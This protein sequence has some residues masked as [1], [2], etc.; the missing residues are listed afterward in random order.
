M[1]FKLTKP[2]PV[3]GIAAIAAAG[4]L[5]TYL[6][7]PWV[8]TYNLT[9]AALNGDTRKI[10]QLVD[11][12]RV[13]ETLKIQLNKKLVEEMES[14]PEM[15]NNPFSGLGLA[16]GQAAINQGLETY[17]TASNVT[18]TIRASADENG[19]VTPNEG[20]GY[21]YAYKDLDN[22]E[23]VVTKAEEPGEELTLSFERSGFWD[24]QM[25]RVS[26][27]DILNLGG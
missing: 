22:F 5:T 4:L 17:V 14:N 18:E 2:K 23:V 1:Q 26:H 8:A 9:Q 12:P 19:K 10:E 11:F 16:M 3:F 13:R 25:V 6:A 15:A 7:S 24:W 27:P 21:S 20:I